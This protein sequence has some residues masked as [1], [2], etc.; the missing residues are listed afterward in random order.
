MKKRLSIKN[1]NILKKN[2]NKEGSCFIKIFI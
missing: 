2:F 1:K